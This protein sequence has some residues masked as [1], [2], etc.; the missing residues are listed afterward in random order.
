MPIRTAR[1]SGGQTIFKPIAQ[2]MAA[3]IATHKMAK[4]PPCG[5]GTAWLERELGRA[6]A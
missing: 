6:S 5:V 1:L 2:M 3:P 4:P